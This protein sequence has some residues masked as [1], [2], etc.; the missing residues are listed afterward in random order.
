[1]L[2][3]FD[4]DQTLLAGPP[5]SVVDAEINRHY[6]SAYTPTVL[7]RVDVA[8]GLKGKCPAKEIVWLLK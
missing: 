7:A 8:G 5:F 3:S 4:Y 1:L 2:I 6:G